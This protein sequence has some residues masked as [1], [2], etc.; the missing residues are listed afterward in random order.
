MYMFKPI[1]GYLTEPR[2]DTL[3]NIGI[4]IFWF[5]SFGFQKHVD[6]LIRMYLFYFTITLLCLGCMSTVRRNV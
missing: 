1:L 6:I 2:I 4:K 5:N 3:R